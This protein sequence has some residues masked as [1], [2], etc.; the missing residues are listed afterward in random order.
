MEKLCESLEN[1][2]DKLYSSVLEKLFAKFPFSTGKV[3]VPTKRLSITEK[4]ISSGFE[5]EPSEE[6]GGGF[7]AYTDGAEVDCT[8]RTLIF[9][10]FASELGA[11]FAEKLKLL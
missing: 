3:V 9:S 8:F 1:A 2:D 10:E 6:I 5:V 7:L 11:Y 4:F